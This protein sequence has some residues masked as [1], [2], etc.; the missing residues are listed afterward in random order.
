MNMPRAF[1]CSE[2][3]QQYQ[4]VGGWGE[5]REAQ[6]F[7]SDSCLELRLARGGARRPLKKLQAG[8]PGERPALGEGF[9]QRVASHSEAEFCLFLQIIRG[10]GCSDFMKRLIS[11]ENIKQRVEVLSSAANG[12]LLDNFLLAADVCRLAARYETTIQTKAQITQRVLRVCELLKRATG[13]DRGDCSSD[14]EIFSLIA[15]NT[16]DTLI[17]LHLQPSPRED[18]GGLEDRVPP[19]HLLFVDVDQFAF[20]ESHLLVKESPLLEYQVR[21]LSYRADFKDISITQI[22][23][24][25]N[26][27]CITPP[28]FV[29]VEK[30]KLASD[31]GAASISL[32]LLQDF[33]PAGSVLQSEV[34]L[35]RAVRKKLAWSQQAAVTLHIHFSAAAFGQEMDFCF[36]IFDESDLQ[37]VQELVSA[38]LRKKFAPYSADELKLLFFKFNNILFC[39]SVSL[40]VWFSGRS[41]QFR[42]VQYIASPADLEFDHQNEDLLYA[43]DEIEFV[44]RHQGELLSQTIVKEAAQLADV[45]RPQVIRRFQKLLSSVTEPKDQFCLTVEEKSALRCLR[46]LKVLEKRDVRLEDLHSTSFVF[47]PQD[48]PKIGEWRVSSPMASNEPVAPKQLRLRESSPC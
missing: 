25:L 18:V 6:S 4:A 15:R 17:E 23:N 38:Q 40:G 19:A 10:I 35:S 14:A 5:L 34:F 39:K 31:T 44:R 26:C 7:C 46:L 32:R 9:V 24:A 48:P 43:R 8:P 36:Q 22:T 13:I 2:C 27:G 1:R 30:T 16:I 28:N 21:L 3:G 20:F 42:V 41:D 29:L 45:P 33:E 37:Q 11:T 47:G 12:S